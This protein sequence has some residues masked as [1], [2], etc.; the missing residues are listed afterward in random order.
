MTDNELIFAAELL[1]KLKDSGKN[2]QVTT[3]VALNAIT[4]SIT[5]P[6]N[7]YDPNKK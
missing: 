4:I 5:I 2:I 3:D 7:T 6:F 1:S